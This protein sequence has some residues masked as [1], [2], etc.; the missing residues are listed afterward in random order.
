[1]QTIEEVGESIDPDSV[2]KGVLLLA[3]TGSDGRWV[4]TAQ[5]VVV[6]TI[7]FGIIQGPFNSNSNSSTHK[8]CYQIQKQK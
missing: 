3:G 6:P 1:M 8:N 7:R 2:S 4:Q 5:K